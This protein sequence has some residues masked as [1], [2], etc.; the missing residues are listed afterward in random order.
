MNPLTPHKTK[1]KKNLKQTMLAGALITALAVFIITLFAA[2]QI[3]TQRFSEQSVENA[4]SLSQLSF[5]NMYQLMS[6]GW[7]REQLLKF[8]A[9]LKQTYQ[10]HDMTFSIYR[11]DI[12][13]RQFGFLASDVSDSMQPFFRKC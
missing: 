13:N 10:D 3:F 8:R 4:E 9:D 2:S 5:D 7:N 11:S 12:V 6:K 1:H